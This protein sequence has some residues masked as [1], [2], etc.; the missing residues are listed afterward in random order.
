MVKWI[1]K[2]FDE[3]SFYTPE[4][5]DT[6]NTII[7]SYYKNPD[8]ETPHFVYFLDGLKPEKCWR[9]NIFIEIYLTISYNNLK[10]LIISFILYKILNN[11]C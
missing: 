8:D 6:E 2:N 3:F 4:S 1:L 7:L 5:F 9:K 10:L 11:Q